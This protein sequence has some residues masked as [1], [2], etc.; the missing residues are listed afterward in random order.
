MLAYSTKPTPRAAPA[1]WLRAADSGRHRSGEYS[2]SADADCSG[3]RPPACALPCA[4]MRHLAVHTE[5]ARHPTE[6]PV[7]STRGARCRFRPPRPRTPSR[8]PSRAFFG[9]ALNAEDA[10]DSPTLRT[11]PPTPA[12]RTRLPGRRAPSALVVAGALRGCSSVAAPW[13]VRY[14]PAPERSLAKAAYALAGTGAQLRHRAR[15]SLARAAAQRRAAARA[16][17][18]RCRRRSPWRHSRPS[19]LARAD[20]GHLDHDVVGLRCRRRRRSATVPAGRT[21]RRSAP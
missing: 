21:G 5:A 14:A 9:G 6:T 3:A 1:R 4:A 11:A 12:C 15:N 8:P 19:S 16:A 10:H 17:R 18:A 13:L 20:A 7:T 2:A